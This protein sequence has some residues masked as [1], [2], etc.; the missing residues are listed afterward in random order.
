LGRAAADRTF[1]PRMKIIIGL[2][3]FGVIALSAAALPKIPQGLLKEPKDLPKI[4]KDLPKTPKQVDA[5][6]CGGVATLGDGQ[7]VT[8]ASPEKGRKGKY[9]NNVDC[10]WELSIPSG[11]TVEMWCEYFDVR[12]RDFLEFVNVYQPFN[13]QAENGFYAPILDT[14]GNPAITLQ[15]KF[16]SNRKGRG[17]GFRCQIYSEPATSTNSTTSTPVTTTNTVTTAPGVTTTTVTNSPTTTTIASGSSCKCGIPNRSDRI[18]GGVKTE[19]NEYPW[20]VGLVSR[21]GRTPFCGGTLIS[22]RHVMT[23][24]HCTAGQSASNIRIILG[25]HK[26][27]DA[28]Q[29]KVEVATI[30]DDPLYNSNT[31][32]NDFSILTLKEPVTFTREISPA[33]LPSDTNQLY[34]GQVATVSGWGTLQSNGNQPTVLMEVDVT[35]TT[36]TVCRNV[37]GNDISTIN[38]CAMDAG[39]DSCQGDSGGPLVIQENGRFALIGVVSYGYGCAQPNVPGV[40]ARVTARKDWIV[41]TAPGTMDSNC[42]TTA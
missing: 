33:C 22:D 38:I 37:Y 16:S 10:T 34:A 19:V 24:A 15:V 35:V 20:Q 39:K 40:Y 3:F 27:D 41:A 12:R 21:N 42:A 2:V 31:M 36:Q 11:E 18:V 32:K 5:L 4:P 29:T 8:I 1:T 23:A 26:T 7:E 28:S 14:I 30:T 25:E 6:P 17:Y 13:G 9:P